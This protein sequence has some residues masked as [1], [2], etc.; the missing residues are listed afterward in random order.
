MLKITSVKDAN[1]DLLV[2]GAVTS[3]PL[4]SISGAAPQNTK[5]VGIYSDGKT[6]MAV[7]PVSAT[8]DWETNFRI[9]DVRE[10]RLTVGNAGVGDRIPSSKAWMLTATYADESD[11]GIFMIRDFATG[12]VIPNGGKL[13]NRS[14][15]L[16]V[17]GKYMRS[18][19][20]YV[21]VR[22]S[23]QWTGVPDR[24]DRNDFAMSGPERTWETFHFPGE[25]RQDGKI[26]FWIAD[27]RAEKSVSAPAWSEPYV[28]YFDGVRKT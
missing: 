18:P 9:D 20:Q 11:L 5:L 2:D 28:I 16:Q 21:S 4:V 3:T 7:A 27:G 25:W 17:T 12:Q 22:T 14:K 23:I 13:P 19:M 1:N 10:Y 24:I 8:G 15:L 26:T 6:R